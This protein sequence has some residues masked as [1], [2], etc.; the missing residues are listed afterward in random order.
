[1][2]SA[3]AGSDLEILRIH[4]QRLVERALEQSAHR[5][6]LEELQVDEVFQRCLDAHDIPEE[7]RPELQQAYEEIIAALR[8]EDRRAE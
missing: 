4:N 2:E 3:V 8:D 7:Q 1:M 5:E 6:T